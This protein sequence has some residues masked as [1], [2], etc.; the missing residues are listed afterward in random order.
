MGSR[1]SDGVFVCVQL[2]KEKELL[3]AMMQHL[4][5]KSPGATSASTSSSSSSSL[6]S[7]SAL[8]TSLSSSSILPVSTSVPL[9]LPPPLITPAK[10]PME[11]KSGKVEFCV[12]LPSLQPSLPS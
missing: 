12:W 2:V 3:Q 7:S 5:M 11:P 10:K 8:P 1:K 4:H 9:P 6:L